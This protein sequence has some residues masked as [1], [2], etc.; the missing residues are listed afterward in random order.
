MAELVPVRALLYDP[1][2]AGPLDAL[3]APPYDVVSELER[4]APDV[5]IG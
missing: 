2:R 4:A 5:R 3:V 1:K